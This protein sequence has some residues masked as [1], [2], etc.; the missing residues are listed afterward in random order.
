MSLTTHNRRRDSLSKEG[1]NG[2]PRDDS[3]I[4]NIKNTLMGLHPKLEAARYKAEAGLSR[5]GFVSHGNKSFLHED[6]EDRLV[7]SSASSVADSS[8]GVVSIDSDDGGLGQD[9]NSLDISDENENGL[10]NGS[11]WDGR[12]WDDTGRLRSS[13]GGTLGMENGKPRRP[14]EVE[15]DEMKWPVGEGWRPL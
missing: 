10:R 13:S 4:S 11:R 14:W 15:R 3:T 7:R 5:R 6:A 9:I 12:R 1:I 8:T 2:A